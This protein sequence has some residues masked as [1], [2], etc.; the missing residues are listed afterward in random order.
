M[1]IVGDT[2]LLRIHTQGATI[3]V[4]L[5]QRI[6]LASLVKS[7]MAEALLNYPGNLN[8][9]FPKK[10]CWLISLEYLF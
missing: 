7:T 8:N 5:W 9:I 2:A 3:T 10:K 6:I 1:N 4:N